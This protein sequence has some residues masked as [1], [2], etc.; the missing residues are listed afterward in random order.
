MLGLKISHLYIPIPSNRHAHI[1]QSVWLQGKRK[2]SSMGEGAALCGRSDLFESWPKLKPAQKVGLDVVSHLPSPAYEYVQ[3]M[4][5]YCIDTQPPQDC[6]YA[7]FMSS[8]L[9]WSWTCLK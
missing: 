2:A 6:D 9:P 1:L 7:Y 5:S 8:R 3:P 4:N